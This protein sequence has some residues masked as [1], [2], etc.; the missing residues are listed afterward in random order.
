MCVRACAPRPR[1]L[2]ARNFNNVTQVID[3]DPRS[4]AVGQAADGQRILLLYLRI[5]F[6]RILLVLPKTS[7]IMSR[8]YDTFGRFSVRFARNQ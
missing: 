8:G 5:T 2:A 6:I 1:L 7:T 4:A 3:N